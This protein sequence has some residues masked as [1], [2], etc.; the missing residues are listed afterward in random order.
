MR[1][2]LR[3]TLEKYAKKI[4]AVIAD[5]IYQSPMKKQLKLWKA[6]NG[7]KTLRLDYNLDQDSI[8]FD[9]GGYE[10]QW[11]SDIYSRYCCRIYVFEPVH[12]FAERIQKRFLRNPNISVLQFGL[13]G[14]SRKETISL[15]KDGSSIFRNSDNKQE[16][17]LI[18]VASWIEGQN[19][20]EI[21]LMK[22]NIEG[23]EYELL[24]RLI[25]TNLIRVIRNIQVQFHK[26][27]RESGNRMERIQERLRETH[28]PTY[29]YRFVWE[30]WARIEI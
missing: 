11:A 12:E 4:F 22:V 21:D 3:N 19:I 26:I 18:D 16:I 10:G 30:N 5:I 7:D 13:G 1:E 29:Q 2:A 27:A 9:L 20:I 17:Q 25:E 8:V 15:C 24:E 6:N 23:G 28:H 14:F